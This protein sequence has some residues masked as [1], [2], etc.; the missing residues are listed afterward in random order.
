MLGFPILNDN[1][2]FD[3]LIQESTGDGIQEYVMTLEKD[4]LGSFRKVSDWTDSC[5]FEVNLYKLTLKI[6]N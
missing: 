3:C 6:S 4:N 5:I 1:G 2:T